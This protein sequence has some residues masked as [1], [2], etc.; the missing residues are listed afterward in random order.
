[1]E[2]SPE[3]LLALKTLAR[4]LAISD[5]SRAELRAKLALRYSAATI[6]QALAH[7]E[8]QGWL[9]SEE[10][11]AQRAAE[12]LARKYKSHRFI[13]ERLRQRALPAPHL[14][15]EAEAGKIRALVEKKFGSCT[16]AESEKEQA[17]RY[18]LY[19]GFDDLAIRM[20]LE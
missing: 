19:R 12:A 15:P 16:L 11:I 1:M 20:V 3:H 7:A 5:R 2:N 4:L 13:E 10:E 18:L 6:D 9:K 14:D 8:A 17:I